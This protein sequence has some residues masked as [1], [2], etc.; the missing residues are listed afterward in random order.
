MTTPQLNPWELAYLRRTTIEEAK[1]FLAEH[2]PAYIKR[3]HKRYTVWRYREPG[4]KGRR[5]WH[6]RVGPPMG[7]YQGM[8]AWR[9]VYGNG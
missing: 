2:G 6:E 7:P 8:R 4:S 5:G 3:F 1:V 9:K